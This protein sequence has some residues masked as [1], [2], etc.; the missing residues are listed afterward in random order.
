[1]IDT[2]KALYAMKRL[3]NKDRLERI[4]TA[5]LAGI[6]SNSEYVTS[7]ESFCKTAENVAPMLAATSLRFTKALI[8]ELE[9]EHE[10]QKNT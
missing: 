5:L 1:M 10:S 7:A 4:A 2:E 9:K 3:E 6:L 8:A